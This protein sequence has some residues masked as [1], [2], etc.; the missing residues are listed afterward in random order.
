[1]LSQLCPVIE[2]ALED[3]HEDLL[4]LVNGKCTALSHL[5]L[6]LMSQPPGPG[7]AHGVP[8]LSGLSSRWEE[9]QLIPAWVEQI[10]IHNSDFTSTY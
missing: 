1:M 7:A 5:F 6:L 9:H 2:E 8:P 10:G 3:M 4:H